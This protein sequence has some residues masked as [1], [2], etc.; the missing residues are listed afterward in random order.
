M[1]GGRTETV[2][3]YSKQLDHQKD[4][5]EPPCICMTL[6]FITEP[7]QV[8]MYCECTQSAILALATD[9]GVGALVEDQAVVVGVVDNLHVPVPVA[10]LRSGPGACLPWGGPARQGGTALP[11]CPSTGL[12]AIMGSYPLQAY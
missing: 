1:L 11:G 5:H 10:L 4:K 2:R 12:M 6:Y 3:Y 8:I 7:Q 9:G